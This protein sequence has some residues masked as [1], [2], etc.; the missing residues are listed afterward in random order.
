MSMVDIRCIS[1]KIHS[2]IDYSSHYI[3]F[4]Y[5]HASDSNS[6]TKGGQISI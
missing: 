4:G 2:K 6:P 3:L 5:H 1:T